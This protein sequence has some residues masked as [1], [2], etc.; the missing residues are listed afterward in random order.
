[1]DELTGVYTTGID[2]KISFHRFAFHFHFTPFHSHP[3][4]L[5]RQ[6]ARHTHITL[7]PICTHEIYNNTEIAWNICGS[8]AMQR[9]PLP[10]T[11][12]RQP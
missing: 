7:I 11:H 2:A 1:M 8:S 4:G 12:T 5:G 3:F 6:R 9:A 10:L